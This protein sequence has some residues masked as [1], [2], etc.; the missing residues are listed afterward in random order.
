MLELGTDIVS[1]ASRLETRRRMPAMASLNNSQPASPK[2]TT[3][4][5]I[6][7]VQALSASDHVPVPQQHGS[8]ATQEANNGP[9]NADRDQF[10][11]SYSNGFLDGDHARA[12]SR[13]V[14]SIDY[15]A[16][17]TASKVFVLPL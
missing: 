2:H 4:D 14:N 6:D 5:Q 10:M 17:S 1:T 15:S 16:R 7:G 13:A 12:Q 11:A 3:P 9:Q 8:N